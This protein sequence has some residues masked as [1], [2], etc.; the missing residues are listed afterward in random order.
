MLEKKCRL[1]ISAWSKNKNYPFLGDLFTSLDTDISIPE[2]VQGSGERRG[3][4]SFMYTPPFRPCWHHL[5][6]TTQSTRA[7]WGFMDFYFLILTHIFCSCIFS[8]LQKPS[9]PRVLTY[10]KKYLGGSERFGDYFNIVKKWYKQQ[11]E[12]IEGMRNIKQILHARKC[13]IFSWL[14][15]LG[16]QWERTHS[17]CQDCSASQLELAMLIMHCPFNEHRLEPIFKTSFLVLELTL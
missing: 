3:H 17:S 5:R 2:S 8:I 15:L 16:M 1:F 6:M 10:L 4:I 9:L 7:S 12:I 13:S 11:D 14:F